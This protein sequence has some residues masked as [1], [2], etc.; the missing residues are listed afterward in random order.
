ML[1]RALELT[2]C[3]EIGLV[4]WLVGWLVGLVGLVWLVGW[5]FG[6]LVRWL[7]GTQY[8]TQEQRDIWCLI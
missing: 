2:D 4:D 5:L 3:C 1:Y 6:C 8:L 7:V